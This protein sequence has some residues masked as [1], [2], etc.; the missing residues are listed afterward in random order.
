VPRVLNRVVVAILAAAVGFLLVSQ[1]RGQPRFTQRLEAESEG[2]LARILASLNNET[3][4]LRDE[5]STLKIQLITLQSSSQQDEAAARAARD[6]LNALEVLAGTVPVHGPGVAMHVD[7]PKH[8]LTYDVMV[9]I[10]Q[11]LRDAGAEAIAVNG[12]RVG[13]ASAFTEHDDGSNHDGPN[14]DGPN[15]DGTVA[16]DGDTLA[17]PYRIEAIGQPDT[18]DA[19][20]AIPGGAVDTLKASKGV[21]VRVDRQADVRLPALARPPTFSAARPVASSS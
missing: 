16:L 9:D 12:H 20:L 3:D 11:E 13:A 15:R 10:V 18:L 19:G 6:Q 8:T 17:P 4:A 21:T 5:I 2:D 1:L 7:D 14:R